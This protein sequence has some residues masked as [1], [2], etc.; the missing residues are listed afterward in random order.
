MSEIIKLIIFILISIV[1]QMAFAD[2]KEFEAESLA[3]LFADSS[4]TD[5]SSI[6]PQSR[7]LDPKTRLLLATELTCSPSDLV[8]LPSDPDLAKLNEWVRFRCKQLEN[9]NPRFFHTPPFL[10]PSGISY[11][12]LARQLPPFKKM[13]STWINQQWHRAHMLEVNEFL[14]ELKDYPPEL[15]IIAEL[16][17]DNLSQLLRGEENIVLSHF[18]LSKKMES[19]SLH[20]SVHHR[21]LSSW[22][23]SPW[24]IGLLGFTF[25]LLLL[26]SMWL[27]TKLWRTRKQIQEDRELMMQTLAHELRHPVT[28]LQL[29]M[30]A[31]REIFDQLPSRG[32]DEFLRMTGQIQR[33]FRIIQASTQYLQ[34]SV[35]AATQFQLKAQKIDSVTNFFSDLLADYALRLEL[36]IVGADRS[37]STD[38]YW[39]SVCILNLVKNSLIHGT[40]PVRVEVKIKETDLEITVSDN[41]QKLLEKNLLFNAFY[42]GNESDGLGLGLT[43]VSRIVKLMDGEIQVFEN[44][45]RFTITV[46]E[47]EDVHTIAS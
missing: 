35:R 38:S 31:Y 41:G 27:G 47:V 24:L 12:N 20:Y 29:S 13:G 7:W 30:E 46:K 21:D 8:Q 36:K 6:Y 22:F 32:Q 33:L 2:T 18:Q 28:S 3:M 44:P 34:S 40:P 16:T 17:P 39:L 5:P 19:N 11:V 26:V 1:E 15:K 14:S 37:F 45:T 42:K 43:I 23:E 10:H 9:L 25:S 4:L